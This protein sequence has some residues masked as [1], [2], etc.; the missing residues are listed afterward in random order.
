MADYNLIQGTTPLTFAYPGTAGSDTFYVPFSKTATAAFLSG[1]YTLD[2]SNLGGNDVLVFKATDIFNGSTSLFNPQFELSSNNTPVWTAYDQRANPFRLEW[3]SFATGD[4]GRMEVWMTPTGSTSPVLAAFADLAGTYITTVGA[5][6]AAGVRTGAIFLK[7]NVTEVSAYAGLLGDEDRLSLGEFYVNNGNDGML[8]STAV[9]G[10]YDGVS[11]ASLAAGGFDKF[12]FNTLKDQSGLFGPNSALQALEVDIKVDAGALSSERKYLNLAGS[13]GS[14]TPGNSNTNFTSLVPDVEYNLSVDLDA[15]RGITVN[16]TN[17]GLRN[18]WDRVTYS[19]NGITADGKT[20]LV[21]NGSANPNS[22]VGVTLSTGNFTATGSAMAVT[23]VSAVNIATHFITVQAGHGFVAGDKLLFLN[24]GTSTGQLSEGVSYVV[25]QVLGNEIRVSNESMPAS[26]L[27]FAPGYALPSGATFQKLSDYEVTVVRPTMGATD[28]YG[29][30]ETYQLTTGNDSINYNGTSSLSVNAAKGADTWNI[31][32]QDDSRTDQLH[33]RTESNLWNPTTGLFV[34]LSGENKSWSGVDLSGNAN[35]G[36]M[37]DDYGTIDTFNV[38]SGNGYADNV[39]LYFDTTKSNDR[40]YLA[41]DGMGAFVEYRINASAGY[42]QYHLSSA[43]TPAA[44]SAPAYVISTNLNGLMAGSGNAYLEESTRFFDSSNYKISFVVAGV[45]GAQKLVATLQDVAQISGTSASGDISV[46]DTSGW[47]I[48]DTVIYRAGAQGVTG[49]TDGTRYTVTQVTGSTVKVGLEVTSGVATNP[50]TALDTTTTGS[51]LEHIVSA[52]GVVDGVYSSGVVK[53]GYVTFSEDAGQFSRMAIRVDGKITDQTIL[54]FNAQ[55]NVQKFTSAHDY[56]ANDLTSSSGHAAFSIEYGDLYDSQPSTVAR[57]GILYANGIVDKRALGFDRLVD[58]SESAYVGAR[59]YSMTEYDDVLVQ[60]TGTG[61]VELMLTAGSGMDKVFIEGVSSDVNQLIEINLGDYSWGSRD[62]Q[63]DQVEIGVSKLAHKYGSVQYISVTNADSFDSIKFVDAEGYTLVKSDGVNDGVGGAG[64]SYATYKIY[65][66]NSSVADSL[67]MQVRVTG[68]SNF[69]GTDQSTNLSNSNA[70]WGQITNGAKT[71]TANPSAVSMTANADSAL[72]F[73]DASTSPY[74]MGEGN[75]YVVTMGGDQDIALGGGNDFLSIRNYGQQLFVS[76]GAGTDSLGMGGTWSTLADGTYVS[77]QWSFSSIEVAKAKEFLAEKHPSLPTT[78]DAFAWDTGV[79]DRVM[80][81]T[82]RLDGTQVYFQAE[83]LSFSNG[84]VNSGNFLP[85][86]SETYDTTARNMAYTTLYGRST[87][88]TV[89]L[90][91]ADVDMALKH[92][93]SW[94]NSTTLA[95]ITTGSVLLGSHALEIVTQTAAGPQWFTGS[96]AITNAGFKLVDVENI[97]LFDNA[98]KEVTVRVAGSSSY[99]SVESAIQYANR[100]DVIFVA[101]TKEGALTGV[102]RAAVNMETTVFVSGG[103]R[104]AFEEGANRVVNTA[105]QLV[106]NMTGSVKTSALDSSFFGMNTNALEVLGAASV[107][108]NGS[109]LADLIVGNKGNN[110]INALAGNDIVFG[111][112]GSDM[113]IG[114]VGN[115]VLV[116]GSS[117]R[118]TATQHG[119]EDGVFSGFNLS[120]DAFRINSGENFEFETGDKVIY[121]ATGGTGIAIAGTGVLT[122]ASPLYVIRGGVNVD[123]SVDVKFASSIGNAKMGVALDITS[124]GTATTHGVTLDNVAYVAT[125]LAGSDYLYGGSGND[126]LIASGVT[127]SL[128]AAGVRDVLTMNGGSGNDTFSLFGNSGKIN[129]FGGSGSDK[130]EI[131][132]N[133][134]D[135]IGVNKSARMVDFAAAQDDILSTFDVTDLGTLSVEARLSNSGV[136]LS[137]LVSPPLPI[138]SGSGENGNYQETSNNTIR[139][140]M[141]EMDGY[142]LSIADLINLHQAHAA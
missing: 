121:K 115:D 53:G 61:A 74:L 102:T 85:P 117:H 56:W 29:G 1:T 95:P 55:T 18:S 31:A 104:V 105:A 131:F 43:V 54:S 127:G 134:L 83:E 87:N 128:S 123:G 140:E 98:G 136:A 70:T 92:I 142:V 64:L 48:G 114:G 76:G 8:S 139:T 96:T 97:R 20:G 118:I 16:E 7:E 107:N 132:D 90:K 44:L 46:S 110:V 119:P 21:N 73:E 89:N 84:S 138:V 38:S 88:D 122:E 113:L 57:T 5:S 3:N 40:F 79:L 2:S 49:L 39:R 65:E 93:G 27:T 4:T 69:G 68:D 36:Q 66:G 60:T 10:E 81:A 13:I 100:G 28:V 86:I 77:D 14:P 67:V 124:N 15:V 37:R 108:V 19:D 109:A 59:S 30:F 26:P 141:V 24:N 9:S 6:A 72:L 94:L 126:Q 12:I 58:Y 137:Q 50:I 17:T 42:D 33:I 11:V 125:N 130:V 25:N 80:V 41:A 111:G 62:N 112:N 91:V 99:D 22:N 103:M 63:F 116:G 135:V 120:T 101:E 52:S 51:T 106:V 82:N 32:A 78:S 34:N 129:L 133:F 23:N 45:G 35:M 75:D 47:S 71:I